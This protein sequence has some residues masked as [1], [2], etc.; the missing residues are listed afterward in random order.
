MWADE[1]AV[2]G[3]DARAPTTLRCEGSLRG[4][5][6]L[7]Q[8]ARFLGLAGA[9]EEPFVCALDAL[10]QAWCYHHTTPQGARAPALDGASALGASFRRVCA[11]RAGAVLCHAEGTQ[12]GIQ[13]IFAN[14]SAWARPAWPNFQPARLLGVNSAGFCALDSAHTLGCAWTPPYPDPALVE[15]TYLPAVPGRVVGAVYDGVGW[16]AWTQEGE[17]WCWLHQPLQSLQSGATKVEGLGEV[18]QVVASDQA[19]ALDRAGEVRCWGWSWDT[20]RPSTPRLVE[21]VRADLLLGQGARVCAQREGGPPRCWGAG[22]RSQ[23]NIPWPAR[24]RSVPP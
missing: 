3:L 13:E 14:P 2:C 12:E 18:V 24:S 8:G 1:G 7:P 15:H 5:W 11:E 21:G 23:G 16:C 10:G 4:A 19:C 22:A 17:V 9:Y 20:A 6:Q